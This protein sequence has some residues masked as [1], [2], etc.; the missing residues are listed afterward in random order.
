MR[1]KHPSPATPSPQPSRKEHRHPGLAAALLQAFLL[2]LGW[3]LALSLLAAYGEG[4]ISLRLFNIVFLATIPYSS[5]FVWQRQQSR[6][7]RL[8]ALGLGLLL[9]IPALLLLLWLMPPAAWLV[10]WRQ[11]LSPLLVSPLLCLL[12]AASQQILREGKKLYLQ[13]A[14]AG[15]RPQ[16]GRRPRQRRYRSKR[17]TH[18]P[19]RPH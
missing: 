4:Q 3:L 14:A 18:W 6:Y 19:R 17:R 11:W 2:L 15:R 16:A 9:S 5:G 10:Y 7:R 13:E 8:A 1:S 12:G